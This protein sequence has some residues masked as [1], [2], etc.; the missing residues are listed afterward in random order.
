MCSLR[1]SFSI[2]HD[3]KN[4]VPIRRCFTV[5]DE[6]CPNTRLLI[7]FPFANDFRLVEFYLLCLIGY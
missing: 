1:S 5:Y 3:V 4:E 6:Q 7:S 2:G